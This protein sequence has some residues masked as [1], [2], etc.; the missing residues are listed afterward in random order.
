MKN[1]LKHDISAGFGW[2]APDGRLYG[3]D[4]AHHFA[5][6]IDLI[7]KIRGLSP[8][9]WIDEISCDRPRQADDV[10][11]KLG[12]MQLQDGTCG[13]DWWPHDG[14]PT[15]AQLNTIYEWVDYHESFVPDWIK[16][17]E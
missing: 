11:Y 7:R 5:L 8:E 17:I 12:Y 15:Q 13:Y 1:K 6:A 3:C 4:Y 10:L 9:D 16:E 2:L 14:K